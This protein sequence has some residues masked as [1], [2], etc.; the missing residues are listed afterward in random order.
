MVDPSTGTIE[1]STSDPG[2]V[3]EL[4][5]PVKG[6]QRALLLGRDLGMKWKG[7]RTL[8]GEL[9]GPNFPS[10]LIAATR[11]GAAVTYAEQ[12]DNKAPLLHVWRG[13]AATVGAATSVDESLRTLAID[14]TS[15]HIVATFDQRP[16]QRARLSVFDG[17]DLKVLKSIETSAPSFVTAMLPDGSGVAVADIGTLSLR[18]LPD[19]GVIWSVPIADAVERLA[20][21][22]S[23]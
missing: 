18:R 9:I 6:D 8:A 12:R 5:L 1:Q 13:D 2:F 20:V 22:P 14:D 23:S 4:I 15:R 10:Y 16:N 7:L 17:H 11:D 19:L 21:S 3:I